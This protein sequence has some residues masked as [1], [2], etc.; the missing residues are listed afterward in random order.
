MVL[1]FGL[2]S[3]GVDGTLPLESVRSS[4]RLSLAALSHLV[5]RNL[6]K[7]KHLWANVQVQLKL[8]GIPTFLGE[9]FDLL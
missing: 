1:L 4:V 8:T 6:R 3:V 2:G 5:T 7:R 9:S